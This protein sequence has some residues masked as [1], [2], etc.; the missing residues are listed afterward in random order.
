MAN[1]E[2]PICMD[3]IEGVV[4]CVITECGH[5]FHCSCLLQNA[6]HN[7]F[8]CPYCRNTMATEPERDE[9]DDESE[10]WTDDEDEEEEPFDDRAL[11]AARWLHQREEGEEVDEVEEEEEVTPPPLSYL[12]EKMM[13]SGITY[14]NLVK[15][16]LLEHNEYDHVFSD[17][18]MRRV[19]NDIFMGMRTIISN[20]QAPNPNPDAVLPII[21]GP[22]AEQLPMPMLSRDN[23]M[24]ISAD[25]KHIRFRE[26]ISDILLD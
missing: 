18:E 6:A 13:E 3:A 1:V 17:D 10:S 4:N 14:E 8:A 21:R 20:Y 19:T 12:V 22:D 11:N 26:P 2:C 9:E 5:K 16:A 15:C 25:A 7:G 24:M 23:S